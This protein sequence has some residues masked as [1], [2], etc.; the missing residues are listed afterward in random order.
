M[1][2]DSA[3]VFELV[4]PRSPVSILKRLLEWVHRMEFFI[5]VK[6]EWGTFIEV[7]WKNVPSLS[8]MRTKNCRTVSS[9]R[10]CPPQGYCRAPGLT[11]WKYLT[12]FLSSGSGWSSERMVGRSRGQSLYLWPPPCR[13][14]GSHDAGSCGV[15][16][17]VYPLCLQLEPTNSISGWW[18]CHW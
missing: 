16:L 7:I 11:C 4:K 5:I 2:M 1:W 12:T 10:P 14:A 17:S 18:L 13:L 15:A 6:K 9:H 3:A 8:I